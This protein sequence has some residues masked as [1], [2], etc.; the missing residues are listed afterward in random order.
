MDYIDNFTKHQ[1]SNELSKYFEQNDLSDDQI[2]ELFKRN[3]Y[4]SQWWLQYTRVSV[5]IKLRDKG[6]DIFTHALVRNI[7]RKGICG[8]QL[9]MLKYMLDTYHDKFKYMTDV[10]NIVD[11]ICDLYSPKMFVE[12][13][14]V[15][16]N[17]YVKIYERFGK[18][19][20]AN[21]IVLYFF[22]KLCFSKS[23]Y[24]ED[25]IF[26]A[27]KHI[28]EN[29]LMNVVSSRMIENFAL[30][31]SENIFKYLVLKTQKIG[32]VDEQRLMKCCKDDKYVTI[33]DIEKIKRPCVIIL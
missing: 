22:A 12:L 6:K 27:V 31:N 8:E 5:F 10:H 25:D 16:L 11:M 30:E 7:I 28:V 14:D 33:I 29:I 3:T 17:F 20:G 15:V 1:Y 18:Y 21:H 32:D 13:I 24:S 26:P 9:S 23:K 19:Y 4:S 2:I